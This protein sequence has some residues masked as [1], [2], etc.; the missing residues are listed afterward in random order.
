MKT[1]F[2]RRAVVVF[3]LVPVLVLAA[4]GKSSNKTTAAGSGGTAAP[5][6]TVKLACQTDLGGAYAVFGKP[7]VAGF[8]TYLDYVNSKGGINGAKFEADIQDDR[9]DVQVGTS[10]WRQESTSGD[11]GVFCITLS[12]VWSAIGPMAE[13][14]K[15]P[16]VSNSAVDSFTDTIHPYLFKTQTTGAMAAQ[17]QKVW[18]E[19]WAKDKGLSTLKLAVI[20][21]DTPAQHNWAGGVDKVAKEKG[22]SI[23]ATQFFPAG[24]TD[25]TAPSAAIAAAKPD[26]VLASTIAPQQNLILKALRD[27][28]FKGPVSNSTVGGANSEGVLKQFAD[29]EYYAFRDFADPKE[30]TTSNQGLTDMVARAQTAGKTADM[31]ATA[32]TLGY[33]QAW[34]ATEGYKQCGATCD[35]AAFAKALEKVNIDTQGLSGPI[36]FSTKNHVMSTTSRVWKYD[37][38]AGH[39]V[40]VSDWLDGATIK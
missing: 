15:V 13:Q 22:W 34:V 29:P 2:R 39:G 7:Q 26:V 12:S 20:G 9:S 27:R 3:A 1:S 25:L 38:A 30:P 4:C 31:T 28:G 21:T 6:K 8:Q 24:S 32:F 14:A 40:P 23:V 11:L 5:T 33:I 35:G 16:Q 37:T 19:G 10:A 36:G 17:Q 18:L